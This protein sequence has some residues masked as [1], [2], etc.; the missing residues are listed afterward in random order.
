MSISDIVSL[1][2]AG[3]GFAAIALLVAYWLRGDRKP[4]EEEAARRY[5]D[6]HGHWPGE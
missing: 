4:D 3:I 2:V 5:F 1:I 6:A